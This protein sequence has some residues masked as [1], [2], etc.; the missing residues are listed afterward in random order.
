V[1]LLHGSQGG[2]FMRDVPH[3]RDR[4]SLDFQRVV[5]CFLSGPGLPFASVLSAERIE[6]IFKKHDNLS[7]L[8]ACPNM[9]LVNDSSWLAFAKNKGVT[10]IFEKSS[11]VLI[12]PKILMQHM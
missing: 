12:S 4:S 3:F 9:I 7:G 6:R 11:K 1:R 2:L 5:D 10:L 8:G